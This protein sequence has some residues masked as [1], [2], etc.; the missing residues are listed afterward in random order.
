[1]WCDII[2]CF[3]YSY[4]GKIKM[5]KFARHAPRKIKKNQ[6]DNKWTVTKTNKTLEVHEAHGIFASIYDKCGTRY[7]CYTTC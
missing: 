5:E 4:T 6:E 7:K 2:I 1:M 3:I